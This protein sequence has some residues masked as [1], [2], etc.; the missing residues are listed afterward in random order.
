VS[1]TLPPP[2]T[3]TTV[4]GCTGT[5]Y[6]FSQLGSQGAAGTFE[7]TFG[8]R[9]TSSAT[10]PLY[11]Y[12]GMQLLNAS[13][14]DIPTTTVRGGGESFTDFAPAT[15]EVGPGDTAYFNMAYSDVTTGTESSCPTATA[16]EAIPP[17]TSTPLQVAAQFV[18]CNSGTVTVSPV[19]G[20][21]SPNVQ[22]TAPPAP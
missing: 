7:V 1:S 22:T 13:G 20:K 21:G 14:A 15:V 10:C 17:N 3:T 5:N 19:F 18:V 11:G 2:A 12:P 9:N 6:T 16:I 4:P 8:F